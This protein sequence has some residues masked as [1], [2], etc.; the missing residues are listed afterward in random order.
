[1]RRI[2]KNKYGSIIYKWEPGDLDGTR[3]CYD[4]NGQLPRTREESRELWKK[5][6]D[7]NWRLLKEFSEWIG[8]SDETELFD[9]VKDGLYKIGIDLYSKNGSIK[10][11][12]SIINELVKWNKE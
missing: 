4:E 8:N 1:M 5:I 9:R 6:R 2:E 3:E 10:D 11:V 7:E 12:S